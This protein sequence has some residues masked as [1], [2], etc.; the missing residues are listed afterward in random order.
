MKL[1][2]TAIHLK[3]HEK[4]SAKTQEKEAESLSFL[5]EFKKEIE[6]ENKYPN[7]CH[8]KLPRQPHFQWYQELHKVHI[9]TYI[10]I[11]YNLNFIYFHSL[12][13]NHLVCKPR[14]SQSQGKAG[15]SH[16]CLQGLGHKQQDKGVCKLKRSIL[17]RM[18]SW[19]SRI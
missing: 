6:E 3:I 11:E 10:T 2:L 4:I 19:N 18:C 17:T 15:L 7:K 14:N 9:F 16:L 5:T 13:N 12:V 1:K 8:L